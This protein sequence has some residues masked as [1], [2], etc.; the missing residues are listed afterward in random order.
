MVEVRFARGPHGRPTMTGGHPRFR[1]LAAQ[2]SSDIQ[3]YAPDCLELLQCIDDVRSGPSQ[4]AEYEGNSAI[5]RCTPDTVTV[6]SRGPVPSSTAYTVEEAE[7]V[8]V[9]YF[10]CLAP[11]AEERRRH[12][13]TWEREHGRP[14]PDR[15]RPGLVD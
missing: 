3:A 6:H 8:I 4:C 2:L 11:T 1:A 13:R 10:T 14:G 15:H 9:A 5:L 7:A 12:L